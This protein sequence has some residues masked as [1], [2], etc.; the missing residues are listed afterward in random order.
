MTADTSRID[1]LYELAFRR[2]EA[3]E[4]AEAEELYR[5]IL[6]A[7]PRQIDCL[8]FIGMIAL[9]SGRPADALEPIGKAIA[10]NDKV[11]AY[12][13]TIAEAYR[14]LNRRDE[15]IGHY[16]K[17]VAL[18]P[19]YWA[20]HSVLA[21]LLRE[22]GDRMAA[23]EHYQKAVAA[24]PD[25][26]SAHQNLAALLLEEGFVN[27]ALV[28]ACRALL[29][30]DSED[31]RALF[32]RSLGAAR[33]L[34]DSPEFRGLLLR[35][36][37]EV[38]ARPVELA[39][40]ALTVIGSNETLKSAMAAVNSV[41]PQR[42]HPK[43]IAPCIPQLQQDA[44]LHK[45]M[46][47]TPVSDEDLQRLLACGRT[48]LLDAALD[49][50]G[51][52]QP[53]MLSFA[54]ALARQCFINE[55]IFQL[56]EVEH[57]GMMGLRGK[58]MQDLSGKTPVLALT[59]ITYACYAPLHKLDRTQAILS[60]EWPAIMQGLL[61]EQLREPEE[62]ARLRAATP[63]LTKIEDET[64]VRVRQQYEENPYPRWTKPAPVRP[65]AGIAAYLRDELGATGLADASAGAPLDILIAGCGSGQQPIDAARRFPSARVL[66]VDLSLTSLGYAQRKAA[67][68]GVTNL[69]FAQADILA[70][71]M[72]DRRFDVIE[73][74]GMLH[75]LA[76]PFAGWAKLLG[77]LK[78]GG[79]MR[80]G[81][82]SELARQD[83]VA[84]RA[85][86]AAGGYDATADS[87]RNCRQNL[88]K[89]RDPNLRTLYASPDFY[90][91]SGCRDLLFHVEEHRMT[92][93][94]IATFLSEQRLTFLGFQLSPRTRAQY[95]VR[96]PEDPAMTDLTMWRL[97]ETDHRNT[98]RGM[99]QF[100][101]Q[102]TAT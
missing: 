83:V 92:L 60:R 15:A 81:L 3:G 28:A 47:S 5:S 90:S 22:A 40:A 31:T 45:V 23:I 38:W 66:A 87:I 11:A 98:F 39:P 80:V 75:H 7:D 56:P 71:D 18:D 95:R 100:W 9:Q 91:I 89:S 78:P 50:S 8:H 84:A 57:D 70:L 99:Y 13:G 49:P 33:E 73:A 63:R 76:E 54:C 65:A 55:Y 53:E 17:A 26:G 79:F 77:L 52:I 64:S 93:P 68:A 19:A 101:V 97:F 67:E 85:F 102:N 62:E 4:F 30:Q 61:D 43:V 44:L 1:G 21:D 14:A 2:H 37:S 41:W 36:I 58:L 24:K 10:G 69:T 74:S 82:Y 6:Q 32:V 12:H 35:A 34:P 16:R 96:F 46:E 29:R 86:I 72:G 94:Q 48:I 51:D 59:L 88:M 20:A 25:L 27:E 42:V